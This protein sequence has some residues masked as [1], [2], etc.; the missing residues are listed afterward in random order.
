[1]RTYQN[2]FISKV[3]MFLKLVWL[4]LS[5]YLFLANLVPESQTRI[6]NQNESFITKHPRKP[7]TQKVV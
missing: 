3:S 6:P 1:M 2:L 5:C 4:D 7:K